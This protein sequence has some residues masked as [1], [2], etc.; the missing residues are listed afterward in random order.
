MSESTRP[1]QEARVGGVKGDPSGT[2]KEES[3]S[4]SQGG[5]NQ[6]DQP[7]DDKQKIR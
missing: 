6:C 2:E 3:T 4:G 5:G 7:V 1:I